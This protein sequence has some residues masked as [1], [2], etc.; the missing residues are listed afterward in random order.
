MKIRPVQ[1]AG[2]AWK[3][4]LCSFRAMSKK[5]VE[6]HIADEHKESVKKLKELKEKKKE[7]KKKKKK[8]STFVEGDFLS[9]ICNK[10]SRVKVKMLTGEEFV[11]TIENYTIYM[12]TLKKIG[13]DKPVYIYKQGVAYIEPID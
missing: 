2:G 1:E 10:H 13:D 4:P 3:C 11:G 12:I 5:V 7:A 8:V 9:Q 6:Q